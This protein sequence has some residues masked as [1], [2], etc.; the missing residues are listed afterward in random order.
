MRHTVQKLIS[1]QQQIY[2]FRRHQ[3]RHCDQIAAAKRDIH[4]IR[5]C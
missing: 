2:Y 3:R 1:T 5:H 4:E